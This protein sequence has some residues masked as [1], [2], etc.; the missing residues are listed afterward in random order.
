MA[1][2]PKCGCGRSPNGYCIGWHK[3]S[4]EKFQEALLSFNTAAQQM[5]TKPFVPV[6]KQKKK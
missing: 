5:G 4:E 3:L 1:D 6:D 2:R